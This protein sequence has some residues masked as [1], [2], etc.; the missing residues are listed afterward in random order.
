MPNFDAVL[1]QQI[2]DGLVFQTFKTNDP[3]KLGQ[4]QLSDH[5]IW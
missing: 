5:V 1:K 4:Q 2:S 3:S